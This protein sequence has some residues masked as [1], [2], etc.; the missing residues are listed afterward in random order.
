MKSY[1]Y[2]GSRL[3]PLENRKPAIVV[4][5]NVSESERKETYQPEPGDQAK[6]QFGSRR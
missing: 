3:A 1:P 2:I 5:K 6:L 4:P